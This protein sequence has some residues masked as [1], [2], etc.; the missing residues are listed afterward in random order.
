MDSSRTDEKPIRWR[1]LAI[2]AAVAVNLVVVSFVV[3]GAVSSDPTGTTTVSPS[4]PTD[5]ASSPTTGSRPSDTATLEPDAA[6]GVEAAVLVTATPDSEGFVDVI[7][8]V[9]PAN[10]IR[11]LTLEPPPALS[12]NDDPPQVL[13]LTLHADGKQVDVPATT[14]RDYL[15]LLPAPATSVVLHYRLSGVIS[16]DPDA[17]EGRALVQLRP[18]TSSTMETATAVIEVLRGPGAQPGLPRPAAGGAALRA[19]E[20]RRVAHGVDGEQGRHRGGPDRPAWREP[21]DLRF[22]TVWVVRLA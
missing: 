14:S 21:A 20:R 11:Q 1:P 3:H 13:A 6:P 4:S 7:E 15:V 8:R 22:I 12:P 18:L 5:A 16:R 10:P 17:R 9:T 2:A 19:P